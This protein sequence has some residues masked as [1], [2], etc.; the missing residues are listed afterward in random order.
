MTIKELKRTIRNLPDNMNICI[1][2]GETDMVIAERAEVM[3][4]VCEGEDNSE[5]IL[6]VQPCKYLKQFTK[7]DITI[8]LN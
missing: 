2:C 8:T 1:P 5:K 4:I 7:S 6:F 3:H